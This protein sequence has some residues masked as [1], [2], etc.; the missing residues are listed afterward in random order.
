MLSGIVC[1]ENYIV[2]TTRAQGHTNNTLRLNIEK[3]FK[4]GFITV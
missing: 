2:E 1:L 4:V 3:L